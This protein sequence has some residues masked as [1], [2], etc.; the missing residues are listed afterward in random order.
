MLYRSLQW[1]WTISCCSLSRSI[2]TKKRVVP[3][4]L[5]WQNGQCSDAFNLSWPQVKSCF[6]RHSLWT[7]AHTNF[8]CVSVC[9]CVCVSVALLR[10]ISRR[11]FVTEFM[12]VIKLTNQRCGSVFTFIL[13]LPCKFHFSTLNCQ[14]LLWCQNRGFI[15]CF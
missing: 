13:Q 15:F 6:Y 8:I 4:G 14:K 11:N 1:N 10:L 5:K 7:M 12:L 9:V 3:T 2:K